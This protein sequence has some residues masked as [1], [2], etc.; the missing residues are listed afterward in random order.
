MTFVS[1][2]QEHGKTYVTNDVLS[3]IFIPAEGTCS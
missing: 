2:R 3:H 1:Y